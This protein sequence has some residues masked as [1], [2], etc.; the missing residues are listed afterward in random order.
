MRG[1]G[2][3]VLIALDESGVSGAT[4]SGGSGAPRVRA[5]ARSP[6]AAGA[7]AADPLEPNVV[8][9]LEVTQALRE[10]AGA[11][12]VGRSRVVLILPDGIARTALV[13]LSG[14]VAPRELA[15]Y[16]VTPGL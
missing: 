3:R 1:R 11:L 4:V 7:L 8:R 6:L 13:E 5:F 16:R 12:E 14:G 9:P 10:V 2:K 15:R